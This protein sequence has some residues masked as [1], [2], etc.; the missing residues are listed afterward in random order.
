MSLSQIK[1]RKGDAASAET[2][3]TCSEERLI[4]DN[5]VDRTREMNCL[6]MVHLDT[7]SVYLSLRN[8]ESLK[9]DKRRVMY[10]LLD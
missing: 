4:I 8:D 5:R 2:H 6:C 3:Q 7:H 9:P 10:P 1:G